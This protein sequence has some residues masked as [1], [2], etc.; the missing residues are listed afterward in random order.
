[1]KFFKHL[2]YFE[3]VFMMYIVFLWNWFFQILSIWLS[4]EIQ[5]DQIYCL[6]I[7]FKKYDAE[8]SLRFYF[9]LFKLVFM[10]YFVLVF[11]VGLIGSI[12]FLY[13]F[14]SSW[15][16]FKI[17]STL[18]SVT[19]FIMLYD[20]EKRNHVI[21]ILFYVLFFNDLTSDRAGEKTSLIYIEIRDS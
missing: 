3:F 10:I 4:H 13:S 12:Y 8:I 5:V 9:I 18:L 6:L 21:F 17:Q 15:F 2:F 7:F 16:L 19:Q 11:F 14:L 20:I 1:M